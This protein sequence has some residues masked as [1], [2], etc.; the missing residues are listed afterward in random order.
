MGKE[1]TVF[2]RTIKKK[3]NEGKTK[4]DTIEE[5]YESDHEDEFPLRSISGHNDV[6][7]DLVYKYER[8]FEDADEIYDIIKKLIED[9][10]EVETRYV[11]KYLSEEKLLERAKENYNNA[12]YNKGTTEEEINEY[13]QDELRI[14]KLKRDRVGDDVRDI[15][16]TIAVLG[17]V[18]TMVPIWVAYN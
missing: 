5:E 14:I 13:I 6:L 1:L 8:Y 3:I 10:A 4:I 9:L 15:K 7:S 2:T 17:V 18:A 16:E 12:T 11:L